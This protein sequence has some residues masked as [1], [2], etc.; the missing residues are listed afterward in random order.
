MPS[1]DIQRLERILNRLEQN[2]ETKLATK[3]DLND[4]RGSISGLQQKLAEKDEEI[5]VLSSKVKCLEEKINQQAHLIPH[6][7]NQPLEGL[8]V[9]ELIDLWLFGDSIINHVDI[10]E[11]NPGGNN[12]KTCIKG[13]IIEDLRNEILK[14]L[15]K[16]HILELL[17][18]AGSNNTEFQSSHY[19]V[20]QLIEL[21]REI[22]RISP[23][24]KVFISSILPR[25]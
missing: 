15:K 7:E 9:K 3:E 16:Y 8:S 11:N 21:V 18:H 19:I 17:I 20:Y 6:L 1:N 2:Q 12:R 10:D 5:T 14:A 25:F 4:I 23:H 13:G 24:T 22:K